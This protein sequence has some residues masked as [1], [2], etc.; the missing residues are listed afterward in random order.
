MLISPLNAYKDRVVIV[1]YGMSNLFSVKNALKVLGCEANI[2]DDPDSLL[3]ADRIILP[4]VGAFGAGMQSLIQSG[5]ADALLKV[6]ASSKPILGICLGMQLLA[7]VGYEHGYH[8]GLGLIPGEVRK[9]SGTGNVRVPHVGWNTVE[10]CGRG[11]LYQGLG[12]SADYYFVHSY[13]FAAS[14]EENVTAWCEHGERFAVSVQRGAV[15]GV[16]FHPEKSH[17]PGLE[18]LKNF[19]MVPLC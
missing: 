11:S 2:S 5:M 3:V 8:K 4:G 14:C 7:E 15:M 17:L 12:R 9:L 18:T 13:Y 16:Q 19:L 10:F 1:N 6:A